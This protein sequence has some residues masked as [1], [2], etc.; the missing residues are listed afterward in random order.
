MDLENADSYAF[1]LPGDEDLRLAAMQSCRVVDIPAQK[2][3]R[4]L[5]DLASTVFDVP[6]ALLSLIENK[7]QIMLA[8]HGTDVT[9][10]PRSTSFCTYAIL[11]DDI[12][13]V[14]DAREDERFAENPLVLK[15]PH[16]RFYA[17]APLLDRNG[18]KVGTFALLDHLAR[19]ELK[20][21]DRS[22]MRD[23]ATIAAEIILH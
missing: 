11:Q 23:F 16:I 15:P 12:L 21:R 14:P 7:S 3:L 5:M 9:V 18:Y 10:M 8:T 19:H 17:G 13:F 1:P 2:S 6:V 4:V 20:E 22:M